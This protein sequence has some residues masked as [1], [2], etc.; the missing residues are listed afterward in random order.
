M[1]I[2]QSMGTRN[3]HSLFL[4]LLT[5]AQ[6]QKLEFGSIPIC[7]NAMVMVA[8]LYS[9][10]ESCLTNLYANDTIAWDVS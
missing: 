9:N 7:N 6:H 5:R 10:W 4:K 2:M 3:V 1:S 8:V